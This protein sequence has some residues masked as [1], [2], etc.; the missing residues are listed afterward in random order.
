[1]TPYECV[2]AAMVD[3]GMILRGYYYDTAAVGETRT[4]TKA[5]SGRRIGS[6]SASQF[7][8]SRS[9]QYTATV[10][11]SGG[12]NKRSPGLLRILGNN[13]RAV[14]FEP[15]YAEIPLNDK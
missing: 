2:D 7:A 14:L 3:I 12:A 10:R 8:P 11:R 5:T 4:P 13:P 1:M 15:S 6:I 9:E